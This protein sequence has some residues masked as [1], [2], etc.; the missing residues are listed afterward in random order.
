[1]VRDLFTSLLVIGAVAVPALGTGVSTQSSSNATAG[2]TTAGNASPQAATA[3]DP[4]AVV[5]S[6]D[7]G[8]VLH[9][10]KPSSVND[11]EAVIVALQE[12]LARSEDA[13]VRRLAAGWRIFKAAE[14]DV[15]DATLYVH[16]V[17]PAVS[18]ADYR[19][20]LWL[21]R[22]LSGAPAELLAKYR[23][24]FAAPPSKL[25]LTEFAHMAVAPAPRPANQSSPE[26]ARNGSPSQP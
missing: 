4:A 9:A 5:F 6:T 10:V 3:P 18:G 11:Y 15:K 21:D 23:D 24:A 17:N 1:M 16:V 8:M 19:P 26:P 20:S 2:N 7:A 12:A 25:S 22:L 14:G 13:D